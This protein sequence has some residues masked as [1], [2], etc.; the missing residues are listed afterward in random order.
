[1]PHPPPAYV[2]SPNTSFLRFPIGLHRLLVTSCQPPDDKSGIVRSTH[3]VVLVELLVGSSTR[4]AYI[5]PDREILEH[6]LGLPL[7]CEITSSSA[8]YNLVQLGD[9]VTPDP[10]RRGCCAVISF[11]REPGYRAKLEFRIIS[12]CFG[13]V[14]AK[15]YRRSAAYGGVQ[16]EC[17]HTIP[18]AVCM[19]PPIS[20]CP[21][22]EDVD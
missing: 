2:R 6:D 18:A 4:L 5:A 10:D 11:D 17:P 12:A 8:R 22:G 1:V 7:H 3:N 9:Q 19:T 20:P 15:R 16:A 21:S 13:A 14:L